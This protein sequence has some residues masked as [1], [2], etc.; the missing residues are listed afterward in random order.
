M[1]KLCLFLA[2]CAALVFY[3]FETLSNP[4]LE[5]LGAGYFRIYSREDVCS[6]LVTNRRSI[7]TGFIYV[8]RSEN[9]DE[10]RNKFT[11][12]YGESIILDEYMPKHEVLRALGYRAVLQQNNHMMRITYAYSGR[13]RDFITENNNRI[14][15]QIASRNGVTTVG[16]PVILGSF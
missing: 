16:W 1:F 13:G 5:T 10:L 4:K 9:A 6:P 7:A 12:I 14:N 15:L 3:H 8:T 2:F 11:H